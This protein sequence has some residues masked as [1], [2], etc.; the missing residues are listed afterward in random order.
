MSLE[1]K[2][3]KL[4]LSIDI[5][6]SKLDHFIIN[7]KFNAITKCSSVDF[8]PPILLER[9]D[10]ALALNVRASNV[11]KAEGFEYIGDIVCN[12]SLKKADRCYMK[13][14]DFYYL[15]K[16]PNFGKESYKSLKKALLLVGIEGFIEC[17]K[18]MEERI[19]KYGHPFKNE[20]FSFE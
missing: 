8:V 14:E 9:I 12:P 11:L 5:L 13:K 18:Y 7:E 2:V 3:G 6:S 16:S 20:V 15:I 1:E 19:R 10:E 4:I 17:P